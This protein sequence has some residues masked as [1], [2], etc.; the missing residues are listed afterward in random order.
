M[1]TLQVSEELGRRLP[2]VAATVDVRNLQARE[3]LVGDVL[4]APKIDA[5]HLPDG[6]FGANAEGAHSTVLAEVVLILTRVE[7]ILR[8]I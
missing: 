4:E 7:Q 2:P 1:Q 5:V 8:Q 3:L 6:R